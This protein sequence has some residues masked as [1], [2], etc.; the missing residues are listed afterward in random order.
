VTLYPVKSQ[1]GTQ[2]TPI[3]R[4][5]IGS[6]IDVEDQ[7]GELAGVCVSRTRDH[8]P[9]KHHSNSGVTP[10]TPASYARSDTSRVTGKPLPLRLG[11]ALTWGGR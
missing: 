8:N 7:S 3:T 2:R 4:A 1:E 9:Q 6:V 5:P 10:A 11:G